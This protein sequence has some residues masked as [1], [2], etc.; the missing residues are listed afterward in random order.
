MAD[1]PLDGLYDPTKF[2]F[3]GLP[4][5]LVR[6]TGNNFDPDDVVRIT[7]RLGDGT[8]RETVPL[9]SDSDLAGRSRPNC[10]PWAKSQSQWNSPTD[11]PCTTC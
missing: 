4:W 10:P 11:D 6:P 7:S 2:Q 3:P 8:R 9:F 5:L 1:D